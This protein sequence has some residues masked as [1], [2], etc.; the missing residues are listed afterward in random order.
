[1]T[2]LLHYCIIAIITHTHTLTWS[3]L[4]SNLCVCVWENSSRGFSVPFPKTCCQQNSRQVAWSSLSLALLPFW[5]C[6]FVNI[7]ALLT[8]G[9]LPVRDL[10]LDSL[11]TRTWCFDIARNDHRDITSFGRNL[12]A[13][14]PPVLTEQIVT[15]TS[16]TCQCPTQSHVSDISASA[17]GPG[18]SIYLFWSLRTP[19]FCSFDPS[20]FTFPFGTETLLCILSLCGLGSILFCMF[21]SC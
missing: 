9:L 16:T 11:C 13:P 7:C 4:L 20:F 10:L 15:H 1:M 8:A 12:A 2:P 6:F 21:S 5:G 3:E 19:L 14:A 18:T 17:S